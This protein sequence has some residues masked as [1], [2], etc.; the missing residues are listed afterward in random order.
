[1][2]RFSLIWKL[3]LIY[4]TANLFIFIPL[5]K[6]IYNNIGE[7]HTIFK[8]NDRLYM[9]DKT[10][11]LD[12][13][14]HFINKYYKN[15]DK[16]IIIVGDSTV[17]DFYVDYEDSIGR[18]L[19]KELFGENSEPKVFNF[20]SGGTKSVY[21][22]ER[23]KKAFEYKPDLVI[24][25]MGAGSFTSIEW[26]LPP[27]SSSYDISL[28]GGLIDAYK[29]IPKL[30]NENGFFLSRELRSNLVPLHRYNEF[31]NE[32][33]KGRKAKK[34]GKPLPY[35]NDWH[36]TVPVGGI[37]VTEEFHGI[38]FDESDKYFNVIGEVCKYAADKGIE[39]MIYIAPIN[40]SI[41]AKKYEA[42]YYDNLYDVIKS[43]SDLYNVPVLNL[44]NAVPDELFIDGGH[45]KE[46]GDR[47]V[48]EKLYE[49][50]VENFSDIN[51]GN[52]FN[53]KQH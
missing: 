4:I 5:N 41:M 19:D 45:L 40:Q 15:N 52:K 17:R 32:Y 38:A 3:I 10:P 23:L 24:W 34:E 44:Y 6:Y 28:G 50:I 48:A 27:N 30:N 47:I 14:G 12:M 21:I 36:R 1:M 26:L 33:F 22:F 37:K 46:E 20:G 9:Y 49:F 2:K 8:D 29:N 13:K 25:Q 42:G 53:D 43:Y 7:F 16:N 39:L 51:G 35:P 31:Y 11:D 18:I